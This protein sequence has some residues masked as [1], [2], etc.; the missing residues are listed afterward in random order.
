MRYLFLTLAACNAAVNV[1]NSGVSPASQVVAAL[2]DSDAPIVVQWARVAADTDT[3]QSSFLFGELSVA[4]LAFDKAVSV[5]YVAASAE[6]EVA[7]IYQSTGADGRE[8]WYFRTSPFA[9]ASVRFSAHYEVNGEAF[10]DDNGGADYSGAVVLNGQPVLVGAVSVGDAL[11]GTVLVRNLAYAKEVNVVFTSDQWQSQQSV[12]ASYQ[13]SDG[14]I[15]T[16]A[17]SVTLPSGTTQIALAASF[18]SEAGEFWDNFWGENYS[19]PSLP[20]ARWDLSVAAATAYPS[21][22]EI[23]GAFGDA[24]GRFVGRVGNARP[25]FS[26]SGDAGQIHFSLPAQ[27]EA[28]G[29]MRFDASISGSTLT[30][31]T[32]SG[33]ESNTSFSGVPRATPLASAPTFGAPVALFDGTTLNGWS[34]SEPSLPLQ[35]QAQNGV[36]V[37]TAWGSGLKTNAN[38]G[39]F[40][41]HAEF[42]LPTGGNSGI[43]LRGRYELQLEDDAGSDPSPLRTGAIYGFLTPTENAALSAGVW[44]S[45]DVQLVG[46][47]VSVTVNGTLVI[48]RGII[49]GI[50]GGALDSNES[51]PGPIVLQG[52]HTSVQF[53]NLTVAVP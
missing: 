12:A 30:G 42:M 33:E 34:P 19:L 7:A 24:P 25:I 17:F 31:T 9:G 49:A 45:L 51:E 44:Q 3:P 52:D 1:H 13:S 18:T 38:Y 40:L 22:L 14:T 35:W 4:N 28:P 41:L 5:R 27:W 43:H 50:T 36:L 2:P 10:D 29:L 46:Q 32:S 6:Q 11:S 15:E 20:S 21:W 39:D 26:L 48:D 23:G 37:N 8:R 16:W 53:R 47:T